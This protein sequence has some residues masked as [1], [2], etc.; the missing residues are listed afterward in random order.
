MC[1]IIAWFVIQLDANDAVTT[2]HPH[3]MHH[4]STATTTPAAVSSTATADETANAVSASTDNK[5]TEMAAKLDAMMVVMFQYLKCR[6]EGARRTISARR[7]PAVASPAGAASA[8]A[9]STS[10]LTP[11]IKAQEATLR[12]FLKIFENSIL[13]THKSKYIQFL[14]R[15]LSRV[16]CL[17]YWGTTRL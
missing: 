1:L 17:L 5:Q 13:S 10:W 2:V 4:N 11:A 9:V 7:T 16:P 14:V 8:D 3:A 15:F 6:M 12:T